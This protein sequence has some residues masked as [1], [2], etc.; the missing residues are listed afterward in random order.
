MPNSTEMELIEPTSRRK[1]WH[2]VR[3]E[4]A[5]PQSQLW[6][7]IDSVWKNYRDGNGE[8]P[9]EKKVQRQAQ[10]GIQLKGGGGGARPDT[11]TETMQCSQKGT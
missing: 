10:S 2:Q 8:E 11:V 3:D 1:S 7:I 4:V 9:E 5:I 6:P